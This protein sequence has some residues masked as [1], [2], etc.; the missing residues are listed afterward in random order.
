MAPPPPP[1]PSSQATATV[2]AP[3]FPS[4]R[5]IADEP[6]SQSLG[7]LRPHA[8]TRDALPESRAGLGRT[9]RRRACS[10]EELAA[11][12]LRIADPIGGVCLSAG[13][14]IP[15]RRRRGAGRGGPAVRGGGGDKK[16]GSPKAVG[17]AIAD[18]RPADPQVAW[19]L[20]RFI[21]QVRAIP[22]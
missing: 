15:P 14:A 7:A 17:P 6:V 11:D 9:H 21:E 8:R 22:A 2:A 10:G 12:G 19:H 3:P 20:A 18:Y 4:V 1:T 13:V 5:M 16:A